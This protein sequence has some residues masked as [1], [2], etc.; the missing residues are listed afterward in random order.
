V[1]RLPGRDD[2]HLKSLPGRCLIQSHERCDNILFGI[3]VKR[4]VDHHEEV[5]IAHLRIETAHRKRAMQI[6]A[7]EVAAQLGSKTINQ[8][9]KEARHVWRKVT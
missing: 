4:F 9:G 2:T 1:L 8:P 7:D 5:N 3:Q 6:D